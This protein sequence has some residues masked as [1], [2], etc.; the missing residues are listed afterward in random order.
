MEWF[1]E[2]ECDRAR[3]IV[4]EAR[5]RGAAAVV[6][7][8][9]GDRSEVEYVAGK[10]KTVGSELRRAFTCRV[11]LNGRT[12]SAGGT[13]PA[14]LPAMFERALA[15]AKIGAVSHFD[16]LPEPAEAPPLRLWSESIGRLDRE[17]MI[18]DAGVIVEGLKQL[19]PAMEVG[20]GAAAVRAR[21]Y[22]VG[23]SGWEEESGATLWSLAG[24]YTLAGENDIAMDGAGRAWGEVNAEYDPA[25]ILAELTERRRLGAR[26]AEPL[27]G[28]YPVLLA[29]ELFR[30]MLKPFFAGIDGRAVARGTSPLADRLGTAIFASNIDIVDEPHID[31]CPDSARYDA[32]GVPTRRTPLV[33]HGT[34][35]RFL[36]D[37]DTAAMCNTAPTGHDDCAPYHPVI[38]AGSR[39][40][41]ELL[42][43]M[44]RGLYLR[45]LMGLWRGNWTNGDFAA[46]V[47]IGFVVEK[48]EI[49]GRAKDMLISGNL[50]ERMR[51]AVEC[52]SDRETPHGF[53]WLLM[54]GVSVA[55][56]RG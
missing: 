33:E 46:A 26:I 8:T 29:P 25:A 43:S 19:E 42:G 28:T 34:L 35:G 14:E 47:A 53:P 9:G 2:K 50:F 44:R 6:T 40:M 41:R 22:R 7:L 12:G 52:S 48:G 23:T 31:F 18:A 30:Q 38:A 24:Q 10:L 15:L 56:R 49:V 54:D 5:R 32:D 17:R 27:E 3:R 20:G 16:R 55:R 21:S 39:P 45:S 1:T 13:D 36:Y 37:C 51:G 11:I 4:E